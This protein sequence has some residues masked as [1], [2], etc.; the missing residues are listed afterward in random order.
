MQTQLRELQARETR[1]KERKRVGEQQAFEMKR[2]VKANVAGY[3]PLE[4]VV[5]R[6]TAKCESQPDDVELS[7]FNKK[8]YDI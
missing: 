3:S 1:Q 5:T 7:D 4:V 6:Q 2:G 8:C